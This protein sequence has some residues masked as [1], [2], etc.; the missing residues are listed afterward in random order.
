MSVVRMS[1]DGWES[2]CTTGCFPTANQGVREVRKFRISQIVK[3]ATTCN[4]TTTKLTGNLERSCC[5]RSTRRWQWCEGWKKVE[6]EGG[7][8]VRNKRET[9]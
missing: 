3:K 6:R 8:R 2:N 1:V 7:V 4:V 5:W 9:N